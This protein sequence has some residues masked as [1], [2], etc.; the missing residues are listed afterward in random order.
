MNEVD[1]AVSEAIRNGWNGAPIA[2][3]KSDRP[4]SEIH[5][6]LSQEWTRVDFVN[7]KFRVYDGRRLEFELRL[8]KF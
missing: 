7:G 2:G 5:D 4:L 8:E 1:K 3:L 6:Y